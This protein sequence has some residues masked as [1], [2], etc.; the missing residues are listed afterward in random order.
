[1]PLIL[2][3]TTDPAQTVTV[4]LGTRSLTFDLQWNDRRSWW[5]MTITDAPTSTI[6]IE[7]IPLVLGSDLLR[8][9]DL[10]LGHFIVID[11]TSTATEATS[12]S[13]GTSTNVY[14]F[15]DAEVAVAS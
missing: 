13:L 5:T 12:A 4:Q 9:Y 3:F 1:M 7:G 11:E 6:L 8:A 14:W 2:P 10:G 15:T